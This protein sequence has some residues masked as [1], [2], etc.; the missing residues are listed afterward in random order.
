MFDFVRKHTRI[1]QGLMVLL[2]LPSFVVFGIQGYSKFA[3][4]EGVVAKVNGQNIM[5]AE[6]DAAHRDVVERIRAKQPDADPRNFDKPEFKKQSLEALVRNGRTA[7]VP[8]ATLI[9]VNI[10]SGI[11]GRACCLNLCLVAAS[12]HRRESMPSFAE[13]SSNFPPPRLWNRYFR[14]PFAA[15]SKL[16]GIIFVS[17]RCH[18]STFSG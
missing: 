1:L 16:S 13:T 6:W 10:F 3:S 18:R 7:S 2:I 11:R 17:F 5:Q 4:D 12:V 15:Y 14:P 9:L 8:F